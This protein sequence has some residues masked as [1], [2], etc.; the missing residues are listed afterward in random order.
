VTL[1]SRVHRYS[2]SPSPEPKSR[3]RRK[4]TRCRWL[5]P[6]QE[7]SNKQVVAYFSSEDGG[8]TYLR[9]ICRLL[10]YYTALHSKSCLHC[11][12]YEDLRFKILISVPVK[13]FNQLWNNIVTCQPFV[14]LRNRVSRHWPVNKVPRRRGDVTQQRWNTTPARGRDDVTRQHARFQGNASKHSDVT[15]PTWLAAARRTGQQATMPRVRLRVY[16]RN[17][18]V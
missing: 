6:K 14:G 8:S 9:N 17:W 4:P 2:L 12:C 1:S 5:L 10:P 7:T 18:N 11:H 3:R 15:Q 16:K 13:L